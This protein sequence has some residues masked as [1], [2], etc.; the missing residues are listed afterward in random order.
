MSCP[1]SRPW[2]LKLVALVQ[3]ALQKAAVIFDNTVE[4]YRGANSGR[5]PTRTELQ[6]LGRDSARGQPADTTRGRKRGHLDP[7]ED[8]TVST[9]IGLLQMSQMSP[10]RHIVLTGPQPHGACRT[11][12]FDSS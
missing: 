8:P 7:L 3:G 6:R 4:Q 2:E 1:E 5:E 12:T 11:P 9:A 10:A